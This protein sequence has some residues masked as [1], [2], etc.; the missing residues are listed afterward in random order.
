M[1][2]LAWCVTGLRINNYS[3]LLIFKNVGQQSRC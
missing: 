3:L 2:D 1:S